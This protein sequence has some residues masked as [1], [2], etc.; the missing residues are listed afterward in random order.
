M[1][2]V[3]AI[4]LSAADPNLVAAEQSWAKGD[5]ERV[6]PQLDKAFEHP[7]PR[8]EL[9]RAYSLQGH[10]QVAFDRLEKAT[11]AFRRLLGVD[12]RFL[13]EAEASPKLLTVF[14]EARRLGAIEPT[15]A[16]MVP[17]P[18]KPLDIPLTPGPPPPMPAPA[19]ESGSKWWLW[20]GIAVLVAGAAAGATAA[21]IEQPRIPSG[22]LGTGQLK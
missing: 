22:S 12:P 3:L 4:L 2:S 18:L 8:A 1:V 17:D 21:Y 19:V 14:A 13:L 7:L 10:A 5:Y 6:L 11:L 20:T 16:A 9:V 15:D